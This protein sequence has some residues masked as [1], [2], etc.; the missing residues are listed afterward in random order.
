MFAVARSRHVHFEVTPNLSRMD[1]PVTIQVDDL[2]PKQPVTMAATLEEEGD[3]F[4]SHAHYFADDNGKLDLNTS[5]SMSGTFAGW[6]MYTQPSHTW[7]VMF[8]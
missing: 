1:D 2:A 7:F 5:K 6:Y 3:V 4:V 8:G